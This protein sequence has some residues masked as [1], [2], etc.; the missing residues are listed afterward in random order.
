MCVMC[1][2]SKNKSVGEGWSK[3]IQKYTLHETILYVTVEKSEKYPLTVSLSAVIAGFLEKLTGNAGRC[4][5]DLGGFGGVT[6]P[7]GLHYISLL[8]QSCGENHQHLPAACSLW[9]HLPET[10]IRNITAPTVY[11]KY[12]VH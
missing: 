1:S 8:A 10:S 7:L 9:Q 12:R 11:H 3:S 2:S 5:L 4:W 6:R